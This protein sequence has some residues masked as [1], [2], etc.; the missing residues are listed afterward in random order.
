[1]LCTFAREGLEM[2]YDGEPFIGKHSIVL[3]RLCPTIIRPAAEST[4][5]PCGIAN[6]L[7]AKIVSV[8]QSTNTTSPDQLI[9]NYNWVSRRLPT[10]FSISAGSW[11]R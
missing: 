3:F 10:A 8:V 9:N 11:S 6:S 2:I 7:R 4:H 5:A 1:M